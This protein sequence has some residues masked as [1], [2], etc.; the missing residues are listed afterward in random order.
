MPPVI[1]VHDERPHYYP[2]AAYLPVPQ[3]AVGTEV[4]SIL[5]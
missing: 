4:I 2:S 3:W 5:L 1:D